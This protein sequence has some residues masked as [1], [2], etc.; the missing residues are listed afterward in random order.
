ML[1]HL[2]TLVIITVYRVLPLAITIGDSTPKS[3]LSTF[4][5]Y[6]S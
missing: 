1:I 2:V 6:E 3:L 5:H 4:Q